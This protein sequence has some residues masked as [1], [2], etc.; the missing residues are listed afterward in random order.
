MDEQRKQ[1]AH[2]T[3]TQYF[4]F[5]PDKRIDFVLVYRDDLQDEML[6]VTNAES[7]VRFAG[8][9]SQVSK[10]S[11]HDTQT[12]KHT[13]ELFLKNLRK[14]YDVECEIHKS[15]EY[16]SDN[17]VYCL[18]HLPFATLEDYAVELQINKRVADE[19]ISITECIQEE[20]QQEELD[21]RKTRVERLTKPTVKV[22]DDTGD[23]VRYGIDIIDKAQEGVAM[24]QDQVKQRTAEVTEKGAKIISKVANKAFDVTTTIIEAGTKLGSSK[25]T[26]IRKSLQDKDSDFHMLSDSDFLT[27]P[28]AMAG[29]GI[30]GVT[31]M[32]SEVGPVGTDSVTIVYRRDIRHIFHSIYLRSASED[33]LKLNEDRFFTSTERARIANHILQNCPYSADYSEETLSFGIDRLFEGAAKVFETA[34]PLHDGHYKPGARWSRLERGKFG[35]YRATL[36]QDWAQ[37]G[38]IGKE[39]DMQKVR[40][41]FG[42]KIG[43]YFAWLGYYN[44]FL[45]F[46]ALIGIIPI[47]YGIATAS[48]NPVIQEICNSTDIMCP[49][50]NSDDGLAGCNVEDCKVWTLQDKACSQKRFSYIINSNPA[51]ALYA[52]FISIWSIVF[53]EFWKR[54]QFQHAVEWDITDI[55]EIMEPVRPKYRAM[56]ATEKGRYRDNPITLKVERYVPAEA[57]RIWKVLSIV[58]VIF[59]IM[60]VFVAIS[61]IAD[62]LCNSKGLFRQVPTGQR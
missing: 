16:D 45:A 50:G 53:L 59:S 9:E 5:S 30:G 34:Y 13:R 61:L 1:D 2:S 62:W 10:Q 44:F 41:Y 6:R 38:K 48:S 11:R 25:K 26:K 18:L 37:L 7:E 4:R 12:F 20:M 29:M 36:F 55:E 19:F 39:Q 33:E 15:S 8:F 43:M 47:F 21:R 60:C 17:L 52:I 58:F 46:A 49:Q 56:A 14:L 51:S 31:G 27:L 40:L 28:S 22:E 42:E 23:D 54:R 32:P 57:T 24:M 3:R 35:A